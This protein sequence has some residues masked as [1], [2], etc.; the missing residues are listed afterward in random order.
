LRVLY[1]SLFIVIADQITKIF[2]KGFSLPALNINHEGMKYAESINVFGDF[3]KLTF[4]ENPGMAFG[5]DPGSDW[6]WLLS[7]FSIIASVG[8][9]FYIYKVRNERLLTKLSLAMILGG[10]VGNLIDRV[11]YG[12]IYGY[13]PLMYGKVVDFFNVEFFNFSLFGHTHER[14]PIFNVADASV[15]VGVLL[16]LL[17]TNKKPVKESEPEIEDAEELPEIGNTENIAVENGISNTGQ[18]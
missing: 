10:A 4:V 11:F 18:K 6:K 12:V 2:V 15:T 13:A 17:F 1:L 8:I 3:F 7:L 14:W 16:L 5:M 9:I